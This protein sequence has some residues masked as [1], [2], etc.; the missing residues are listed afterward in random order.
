LLSSRGSYRAK[1][2]ESATSAPWFWCI[3]EG[4][5]TRW[6]AQPSEAGLLPSRP[7]PRTMSGLLVIARSLMLDM[8]RSRQGDPRLAHV[9]RAQP[10]QDD[11]STSPGSSGGPKTQSGRIFRISTDVTALLSGGLKIPCRRF[12]S[13]SGTIPLTRVRV[14]SCSGSCRGFATASG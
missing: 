8:W 9:Y 11:G 1:V 4:P 10:I 3:K 13:V 14:R 5:V 12:N 7:S 6:S 2:F